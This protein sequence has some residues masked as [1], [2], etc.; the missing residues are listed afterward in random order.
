MA[1]AS[2]V[3]GPLFALAQGQPI[4][5]VAFDVGYESASAF[6]AMFHRVFGAPPSVYLARAQDRMRNTVAANDV[7]RASS[8]NSD[9]VGLL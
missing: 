6:S 9:S 4:T 7:S 8:P 1:P 2:P 5:S 3:V